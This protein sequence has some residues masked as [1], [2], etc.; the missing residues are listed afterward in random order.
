RWL[1][2]GGHVEPEDPDLPAAARREVL[3]ET[4]VALDPRVSPA[5]I[6]VDV[7]QIPART[8]EPPHFHHDIVFRFVADDDDRIAPEWGRDV[9]WYAADRL[10]DC[11]ADE[12]LRRSVERA[13]AAR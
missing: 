9:Q 10:D 7:H 3:E 4:G 11:D 12:P 2:P 8:D 1:Q 5:L 6:G 13:L